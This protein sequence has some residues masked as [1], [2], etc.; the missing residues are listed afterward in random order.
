MAP[1]LDKVSTSRLGPIRYSILFGFTFVTIKLAASFGGLIELESEKIA[2]D[3]V[4]WSFFGRLMW[5]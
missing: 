4:F 3:F 5:S 1:L 2:F